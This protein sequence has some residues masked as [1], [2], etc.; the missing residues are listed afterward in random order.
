MEITLKFMTLIQLRIVM[1]HR[2]KLII[3]LN[4]HTNSRV[5]QKVLA[6]NCNL[7]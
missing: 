2:F 1:V 5:I 4:Y 6:V 3:F 7:L